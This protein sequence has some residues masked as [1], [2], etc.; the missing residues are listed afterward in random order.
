MNKRALERQLATLADFSD[1]C[2]PLEQYTTPADIATHLIHLAAL[3]GDLVDR[4]VLDLGTGTGVLALAT[5]FHDPTRVVGID[6]DPEV[7]TTA[8]ANERRLDPPVD[9]AWL[10]GDVTQPPVCVEDRGP[11]TVV[12]NPPFGAQAGNEG[13]D[14]RFLAAAA[15]LATVSY[16]LHNADS[17]GFIE[18][19]TADAGGTVTDAFDVQ[20]SLDRQFAHHSDDRTIIPAE[21]YRIEWSDRAHS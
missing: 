7:L 11:V 4:C 9:V 16:S 20:L 15:D 1:P 17:R 13:A 8:R 6:L 14:R 21:A 19:F 2:A 18:A 12:M 5:A 3:R 10:C